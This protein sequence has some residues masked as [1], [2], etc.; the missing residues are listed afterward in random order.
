MYRL[1]YKIYISCIFPLITNDYKQMLL[2]SPP[3]KVQL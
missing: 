1:V 3:N 2:T